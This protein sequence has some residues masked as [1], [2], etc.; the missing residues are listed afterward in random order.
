MTRQPLRLA[1]DAMGT[2]FELVLLA[3]RTDLRVA[4]EAAIEEIETWHRR[5]SRFVPDSLVS[6]INREAC[7]TP[8][9]LDRDTFELLSDAMDVWRA[10]GGAFDVTVAAAMTRTEHTESAVSSLDGRSG[11]GALR[12]DPD[13]WTIS[14]AGPHVSIDLGGIG[15]GHALDC[16]ATVLRKVGVTAA[17]MHGGTSSVVAIGA[18]ANCDGWRV[19]T[20]CRTVPLRDAAISVSDPCGPEDGRRS[21]PHIV[22]PRCGGAV[23]A[24]LHV[25]VVGPSARLADAWS[26]A[27]VVLGRTPAAFPPAFSAF[28]D[29][30][31]G[32]LS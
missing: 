3:G 4:G 12:L 23:A 24:P 16:A 9:S 32:A 31:E 7:H 21:L 19:G 26:T 30:H 5:L 25:T 1:V 29:V 2:R 28:I 22:N 18:P 20:A 11:A 15:K 8:V 27:L 10:S 17:L 6:H 14:L 13:R